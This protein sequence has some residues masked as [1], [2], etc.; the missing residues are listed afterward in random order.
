[1]HETTKSD[2][3][4]IMHRLKRLIGSSYHQKRID[5]IVTGNAPYVRNNGTWEGYDF[6]KPTAIAR[7]ASYT[8]NSNWYE[9]S[10]NSITNISGT[11]STD[12]SLGKEGSKGYLR[13]NRDG[14]Y[15]LNG[16]VNIA[17]LGFSNSIYNIGF[18]TAF[19]DN[20]W[21]FSL[22]SP[23]YVDANSITSKG[24]SS[25]TVP[26]T[27]AYIKTGTR[28]TLGFDSMSAKRTGSMTNFRIKRIG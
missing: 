10:V 18:R 2:M 27:F 22:P 7:C 4:M 1:M 15:A 28:I 19:S 16:F 26:T 23:V 9:F 20:A 12:Y 11:A 5:I 13:V 25:L 21:V 24:H 17:E 8:N 14:M 3:I 6:I